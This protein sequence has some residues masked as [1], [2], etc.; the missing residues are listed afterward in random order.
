MTGNVILQR[1]FKYHELIRK[2]VFDTILA[3]V[4]TRDG[5]STFYVSLLKNIIQSSV[6]DMSDLASKVLNI[7]S[8][9]LFIRIFIFIFLFLDKT[10]I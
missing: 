10:N 9:P 5:N 4:V 6:D 7:F 3:R 1:T 2:K 8:Y